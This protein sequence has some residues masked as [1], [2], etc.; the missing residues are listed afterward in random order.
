MPQEQGRKR[1]LRLVQ[2]IR[3]VNQLRPLP[4]RQALGVEVTR[5][6]RDALVSG[7]YRDGARLRIETLAEELGVSAMPVREALMT[8]ANEGL[9]QML[10]RRGFRVAV[11]RQNEIR[12]SFRINAFVAGLLAEE[13]ARVITPDTANVL[14]QV[15][16]EFEEVA[17]KKRGAPARS[18][19]L[20]QLN[21]AFHRTINW[22][23]DS[24]RLRWFLRAATRFVPS[25]FYV[26]IPGWVETSLRDHPLLIQAL[27][28]GDGAE[29]RRRM[30]EHVRRAGELVLANLV[31]RRP[32]EG[33]Y[34]PFAAGSGRSTKEDRQ[35][36]A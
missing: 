30:E 22:L 23:P 14:R 6:L 2:D 33:G 9:I 18:A 36:D 34:P 20:E 35:G 5:Y 28:R 3:S 16:A 10:P 8:L 29:A 24:P 26:L 12:D 27:E 1:K 7:A 32:G 25:H 4:L 19:R 11:Q 31:E 13:A 15:Q 17:A 21:Y